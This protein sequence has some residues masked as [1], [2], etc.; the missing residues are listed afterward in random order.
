MQPDLRKKCVAGT[1][2]LTLG[3]AALAPPVQAQLPCG[4]SPPEGSPYSQ[5][6]WVDPINGNDGT[7]ALGNPALPYRTISGARLG[8]AAAPA[9]ETPS[10]TFRYLV[11]LNPGIYSTAT[12][13]TIV[14]TNGVGASG[15][16]LVV[17]VSRCAPSTGCSGRS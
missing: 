1:A 10:A 14:I 6:V 8:I 9:P 17:K 13:G 3:L 16:I 15:A 7:A 11:H 5:E 4:F 2:A 12:N